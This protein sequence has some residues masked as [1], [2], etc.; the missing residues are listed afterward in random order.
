[1]LFLFP[2][3]LYSIYGI[4]YHFSAPPTTLSFLRLILI[5]I[6]DPSSPPLSVYAKSGIGSLGAKVIGSCVA[7]DVG[8][9]N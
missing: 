5:S 7:S 3:S 1:M 6:C 9:G 8:A 4:D 2:S